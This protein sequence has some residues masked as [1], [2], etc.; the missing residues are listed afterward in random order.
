[1]NNTIKCKDGEITKEEFR[2]IIRDTFEEEFKKPKYKDL[3]VK[4]ESK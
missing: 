3:F 4:K 1:M 2:K